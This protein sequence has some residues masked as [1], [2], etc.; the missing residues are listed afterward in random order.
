MNLTAILRQPVLSLNRYWQ[1]TEETTVFK[2]LG[3]LYRGQK[4]AIDTATMIALG[5]E[6]WLR[7]PVRETDLLIR[8]THGP[9]RVPRVIVTAYAGMPSK[10]PKK[11]RRG[12]AARDK[13]V[14]G[15]SG[16]LAH[17]GNVDHVVPL[18]QGGTDEWTNLVWSS[19]EINTIKGNRTPEQAGLTLRRK[20][21]VP[22][23]LPACA[24]IEP[25][26]DE[27]LHFLV[28]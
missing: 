16:R 1:A 10:R 13:Y 22:R 23:E 19:R 11:N 25:K 7:L 26:C 14:C 5:W 9:V 24:L 28:R 12:V 2:A 6:D 20:P 21:S 4:R 15:Y 27:W 18:G 17:D 8:T 3:D